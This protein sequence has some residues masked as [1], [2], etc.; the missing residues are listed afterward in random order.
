MRF[1]TYLAKNGIRITFNKDWIEDGEWYDG[2]LPYDDEG[3]ELLRECLMCESDLM[4]FLFDDHIA[5]E[6][7]E[8]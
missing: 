2:E 1:I 6:L 3:Q 8:G 7:R 5:V 4:S